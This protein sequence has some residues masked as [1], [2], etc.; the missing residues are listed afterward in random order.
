MQKLTETQEESFEFARIIA[1]KPQID[2]RVK[3][4]KESLLTYES[5][6]DGLSKEIENKKKSKWNFILGFIPVRVS[7]SLT[8]ADIARHKLEALD[9]E[10][11]IYNHKQYYENWLDRRREYEE[12][13]DK[14]TRE[15]NSNFD[16]LFK[17]SQKINNPRLKQALEAYKNDP[18]KDEL[19]TKNTFYLFMKQEISN[20]QNSKKK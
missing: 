3:F 8:A 19:E 17:K 5:L 20:F 11:T 4:Y 18:K 15:C 16:A 1:A 13:M 2:H 10:D 9:I 6:Y 12:K 7:T 14:V